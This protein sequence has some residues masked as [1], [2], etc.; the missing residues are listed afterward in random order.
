M[1]ILLNI[2]LSLFLAWCCSLSAKKRGRNPS[3][4]FIA[5][6]FFGIFALITLFI[7]PNRNAGKVP[8]G[9]SAPKAPP[10]E[11]ISPLHA[12]KMWYYLGEQ[13]EQFGP[14]SFHALSR[15]WNEGLVREQTF[16]WNEAMENWLHFRDVIH[17]PETIG[18]QKLP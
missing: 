17:L 13:Q 9:P 5:G 16:V 3:T 18:A 1:Y 2:A 15:A 7:L 6:A 10:L 8:V 12:E 4:W 11:A 14:M